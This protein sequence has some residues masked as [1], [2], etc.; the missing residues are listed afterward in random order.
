[1]RLSKENFQLA[2]VSTDS[3]AQNILKKIKKSNIVRQNQ[4]TLLSAFAFAYFL[5]TNAKSF[6]SAGETEPIQFWDFGGTP[7]KLVVKSKLSPC[8]GSAASSKVNPFHK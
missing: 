7:A 6:I 3:P 8:S 5:S 4:Q 1:M 2:L